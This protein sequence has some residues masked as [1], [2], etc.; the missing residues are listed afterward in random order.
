MMATRGALGHAVVLL[1]FT[2]AA[3]SHA[4]AADKIVLGTGV[5][6]NFAAFYVGVEAGVFKKHDIDA[7]LKL[8]ASGGAST[9]YLISGDIQASMAGSLAGVVAHAKAPQVVMVGQVAVVRDYFAAMA[10][11]SI[12]DVAD[13]RGR[14]VGVAI[15]T[16]S[17]QIAIE[18]L[19]KVGMTLKDVSVINVEPPEMLA[20][21]ERRDIVAYFT[22]EPWITRA[23]L[24]LGDRVHALPG[25]TDSVSQNDLYMDREW[26]QKNPDLALRFLRAFKEANEYIKAN[27]KEVTQIVSK[28]LKLEPKL[29]QELLPKCE[30]VLYLNEGTMAALKSD[31]QGLIAGNRLK[32]PFDYKSYVYSDL[33]RKLE[34]SL[35]SY[36]LPE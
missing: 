29:V 36:K 26:I 20:A 6:P 7:E 9:P 22:W 5:D 17:E 13:L 19:R 34:P 1:L 10:E 27:P 23:K 3:A 35:M 16:S 25:T 30:Y 28:V 2:V 15:G 33:L 8:F 4:V 24:A 14:K 31:V 21:L 11:S 32:A 12:K 18:D